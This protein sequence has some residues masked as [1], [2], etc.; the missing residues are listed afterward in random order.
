ME[1]KNCQNCKNDFT[2][3]PEDFEFYDKVKV[4]AP[5]LCPDC[6]QQRRYAWRNERTLYRRNCDLC[7]ESTV[8]IYSPNKPFKVYCQTCWWGD[9]WDRE[10]YGRDFDFNRPFFEQFSELQHEVP[11]LALLNKNSTN[12]EYTNHSADNKNAY[13]CFAS[14]G[15]ENLNYCTWVQNSFDCVDCSLIYNKGE[16]LYECIDSQSSYQSQ[17]CILIKDSTNCYYCFDVNGSSNC[18]MSCNLRNRMYVFENVQYSKEDY[19]EKMKEYDMSSYT[20]REELLKKFKKMMEEDAIHQC[21]IGNQNV[22]SVGNFLFN[23]KNIRNSFEINV[24]ENDKYIFGALDLNDSMDLYHVGIKTELCY[25]CHGCTRIYNTKFSHLCYDNAH[26]D[27]C[28]SCQ[29]SQNLFG[30]VS[31]NKGEYMILNK[32]YSKEEYLSLKEKI[33]KHM[34]ETKE[35]GE[36]LPPAIAPVYYNETRG[37]VYMPLTKD[38]VLAKGWNWEDK[39]P[40]VFGKGTILAD[41][42]PDSIDNIDDSFLSNIL[43]CISC[44]KNYNLTEAEFSFYKREII[45]IPRKCADCREKDRVNLRLPRKLWHRFCMNEGCK[46]EFETSY[47]PDRPEKVYCESCYNKEIY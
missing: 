35:Y 34:L 25:E 26:I 9:G 3:E 18:F 5:T 24:G 42:I 40:G 1:T 31:I 8:T 12:S 38:E 22:N 29:N 16:R 47:A 15:N 23:C 28:D 20:V 30:C 36:Y 17:N 43:T 10:S 46:N 37:A 44:T 7:N 45:P 13:F 39:V 32:K 14:F 21:M 19:M 33:I 27:Y 41:E 11:R 4:P 6:R 2:I